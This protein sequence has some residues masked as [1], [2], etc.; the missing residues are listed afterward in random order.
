[1]Y[2]IK[3]LVKNQYMS[4]QLDL[5]LKVSQKYRK[6]IDKV[7]IQGFNASII[8]YGQTGTGKTYTMEGFTY[9]TQDPQKGII[10]RTI[11]DIFS[12]IQTSSDSTVY[13]SS[14]N[15]LIL[16]NFYDQ[17]LVLINIQ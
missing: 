3:T 5:R 6:N 9:N 11:D 12:F 2:S 14:I 16:D 8:A 15:R 10:P 4:T 1:M 13:K 17:G 7:Y